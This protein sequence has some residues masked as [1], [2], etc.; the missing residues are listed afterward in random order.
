MFKI[1]ILIVVVGL[2]GG[3]VYGG[4]RVGHADP[5]VMI[6]GI[7]QGF[8]G[9]G[10]GQIRGGGDALHGGGLVDEVELVR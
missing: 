9:H 4:Q 10:G 6:L 2:V 3:I 1:Y 5:S 7:G 8:L